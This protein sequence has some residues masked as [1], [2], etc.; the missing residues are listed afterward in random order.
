MI[1]WQSH[2]T[3]V[4]TSMVGSDSEDPDSG[5]SNVKNDGLFLQRHHTG[6]TPI[7]VRDMG[8]HQKGNDHSQLLP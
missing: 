8:H 4:D 5:R 7:Q 2:Q 1:G 3:S 6:T